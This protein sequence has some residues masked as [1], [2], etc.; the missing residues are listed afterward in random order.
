MEIHLRQPGD[1]VTGS[2]TESASP[3]KRDVGPLPQRFLE[4]PPLLLVELAILPAFQETVHFRGLS[5]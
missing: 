2:E 5:S 4:H 3:T 1:R